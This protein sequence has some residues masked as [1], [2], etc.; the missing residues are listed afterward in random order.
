LICKSVVLFTDW[1]TI[2][3]SITLSRLKGIVCFFFE[4]FVLFV[5]FLT[6]L[7]TRE[8]FQKDGPAQDFVTKE[9]AK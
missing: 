8:Y 9:G 3:G 4:E 6:G 2:L 1:N 5:V 7:A